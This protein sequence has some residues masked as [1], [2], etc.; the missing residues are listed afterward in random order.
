M[1]QQRFQEYAPSRGLYLNEDSFNYQQP[2]QFYQ[3][4]TYNTL[5]SARNSVQQP[6]RPYTLKDY[7]ALQSQSSNVRRGGLGPNTYTEDWVKKKEKTD[8]MMVFA[9][10][11]R[12]SNNKNVPISEVRKPHTEENRFK[13]Q[14]FP[15]KQMGRNPTEAYQTYDVDREG[16]MLG[17]QLGKQERQHLQY[18]NTIDH[19]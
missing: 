9:E 5:D 12:I 3:D 17:K 8:R 2:T 1:Q 14:R 19:L 16:Y 13:P 7:K 10:M 11:V 4:Q 6:F 15:S 18:L